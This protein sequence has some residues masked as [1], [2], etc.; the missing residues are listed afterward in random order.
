[1]TWQSASEKLGLIGDTA[2]PPAVAAGM[3]DCRQTATVDEVTHR[4]RALSA[5]VN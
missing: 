5:P 2:R 4:P 1:M 3:L